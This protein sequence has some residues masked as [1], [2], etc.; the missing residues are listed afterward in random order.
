[1]FVIL[2]RFISLFKKDDTG[3]TAI[4]YGLIAALISIIIVAALALIGFDLDNILDIDGS[5]G[6]NDNNKKSGGSS[7]SAFSKFF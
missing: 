6:S 3:S 2:L 1:M 4:E 5:D 7:G